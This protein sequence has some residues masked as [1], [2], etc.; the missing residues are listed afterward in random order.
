MTGLQ[1]PVALWSSLVLENDPQSSTDS[2]VL[3]DVREAGISMRRSTFT[4]SSLAE[5]RDKPNRCLL[6]SVYPCKYVSFRTPHA[7][8][9]NRLRSGCVSQTVN[10]RALFVCLNKK[11]FPHT[12]LQ[13]VGQGHE[14]EVARQSNKDEKKLEEKRQEKEAG[15][16]MPLQMDSTRPQHGG[17]SHCDRTQDM[18]VA[19][20]YH[21]WLFHIPVC[22]I[23]KNHMWWGLGLRC[24]ET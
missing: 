14:Q 15:V 18:E 21:C 7:K 20:Q 6:L 13:C 12:A 22:C 11:T 4:V 19:L 2:E 3:E 1:C 23:P 9:F 17:I 16:A 24:M 8:L 5:F 10:I